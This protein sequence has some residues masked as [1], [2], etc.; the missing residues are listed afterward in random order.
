M[1]LATTPHDLDRTRF[2]VVEVHAQLLAEYRQG[3]LHVLVLLAHVV[4]QLQ[5][6]GAALVEL[7]DPGLQCWLSGQR[8]HLS[9]SCSELSLSHSQIA[10]SRYNNTIR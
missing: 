4:V 3:L 2:E 1:T 6:D 8:Y 5:I 9:F 7:L 10:N